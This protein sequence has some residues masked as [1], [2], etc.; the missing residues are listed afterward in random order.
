M[1]GL[2]EPLKARALE[3][4]LSPDELALV[5]AAAPTPFTSGYY[6]R[7]PLYQGYKTG[8]KS[9]E[10]LAPLLGSLKGFDGGATDFDIGPL[11]WFLIYSDHMVGYRFI[12]RGLQETDIQV[13]WLVRADAEEGQD[14]IKEDLTWLWHVTSLDDERI[15]RHNQSGVNSQYFQP[16]PLGEMETSIQ[17][18]YDFYF[19]MISPE[20]EQRMAGHG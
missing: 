19:A 14:Y 20:P 2:V 6:R 3:V 9:G 13:V 5:G 18:F 11:N 8:S 4:G 15:I 12:P 7:Y 10:A 17:D 1:A 16:G